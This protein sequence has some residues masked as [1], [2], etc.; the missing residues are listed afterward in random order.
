MSKPLYA[1]IAAM[2]PELD[3]LLEKL[4]ERNDILVGGF[5]FHKGRIDHCEVVL[6]LSGIGKVN[7]AI[8][9]AII[10]E[11]FAPDYVINTGSA[12]GLKQG[13]E[14]GDVV[15]GT[16]VAHHDVDVTAF[17][18]EI[19][20]VP[21]LPSRY[22]ASECLIQAA[23]QAALGYKDNHTIHQGLIVSG[24]QFIGTTE[25]NMVIKKQFTDVLA[26]EMEAVA[27]AQTCHQL[28][29]AFVIIRAISDNGDAKA[30]INF[31]EFLQVAGKNSAQMVINLINSCGCF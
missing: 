7:A 18:Y 10:I 26:V 6:A 20:Q 25:Q 17:G 14:I 29:I 13:M 4:Q 1:I 30:S 12:G 3:C 27:I 22:H 2:Q 19:G 31:D 11:R 9:T 16:E 23:K 21:K 28:G 24:D 5:K 15:I 8:T